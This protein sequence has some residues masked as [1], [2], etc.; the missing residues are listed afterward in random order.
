MKDTVSSPDGDAFPD[1]VRLP[2]FCFVPA[3][4]EEE[5]A[6]EDG[7]I[8]FADSDFFFAGAA[9]FLP[10]T[11]VVFFLDTADDEDDEEDWALDDV[12]LLCCRVLDTSIEEEDEEEEEQTPV[13]VE[14]D[15]DSWDADAEV[16]E[17]EEGSTPKLNVN[18]EEDPAVK[19]FSVGL[20]DAL[21]T[22]P[23]EPPELSPL[24]L[25]PLLSGWD[26]ADDDKDAAARVPPFAVR[27]GG[28]LVATEEAETRPRGRSIA[29]VPRESAGRDRRTKRTRRRSR[30]RRCRGCRC[31]GRL[32]Q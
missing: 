23:D 6:L 4:V 22:G 7:P 31:R 29:S 5:A 12:F 14:L 9:V 16:E 10:A 1:L 2:L 20:A 8:F 25:L 27:A 21:L 15:G 13:F 26:D 11:P 32:R 18:G 24:P 17:E 28:A 3:E 19:S 30:H